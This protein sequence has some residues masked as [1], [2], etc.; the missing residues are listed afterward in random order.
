MKGNSF[1]VAEL[2]QTEMGYFIGTNWFDER[3]ASDRRQS[4]APSR[5]LACEASG[6]ITRNDGP[7]PWLIS[8]PI[9]SLSQVRAMSIRM[10]CTLKFGAPWAIRRHCAAC[11]LH[12]TGLI[13]HSPTNSL[14]GRLS[15]P[16]CLLDDLACRS[17]NL[18]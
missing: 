2:Q 7:F 8:A 10:A 17:L 5:V 3:E 11:S 6:G 14:Q 13:T 16:V 1:R 9:A 12:S 15:H 18:C 4:D